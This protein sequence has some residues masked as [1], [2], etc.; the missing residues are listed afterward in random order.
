MDSAGY[1]QIT[2]TQDGGVTEVPLAGEKMVLGR[3]TNIEIPLPGQTVSRKHAELF[4]DPYGRWWLR[5]LGSRNGT[6]VNG[7]ELK[8]AYTLQ[9]G[10]TIQ[11]EEFAIRYR[12]SATQAGAKMPSSVAGMT[13]SAAGV[14]LGDAK[15]GPVRSLKDMTPP[16]I[17]AAHL[18]SLMKFAGDLLNTENDKTRL[19]MLCGLMV[20]ETF[21]GNAALALR[22]DL[23]NPGSEPTVLCPPLT[24]GRTK[25][26]YISKTLLK[27]VAAARSPVVASNSQGAG[28]GGGEEMVELSLVAAVQELSAVACPIASDDQH[29]D[30]LYLTLPSRFG[31]AEWLAL[32]SLAA[33]QYQQANTAWESRRAAQEQAVIEKELHRAREIQMRLVP[34]DFKLDGLDVGFGFEPCKWV[35]GDYVDSIR[36]ADGRQLIVVMDVCGK[37]MQAA[38]ITNGLHTTVHLLSA[39]GL[40]MVELVTKMNNHL[41]AS[42]PDESFVTMFALAIDPKSGE[43]EAVNCGHPPAFIVK[44]S[45]ETRQ[46]KSG[47]HPPL[48]YLEIEITAEPGKLEKRELIAA[49]TD[50]LS[51]MVNEEDKMLE[52]DGV[53]ERLQQVYSTPGSDSATR[54]NRTATQLAAALKQQLEHY[55]GAALPNDD[56]SFFVGVKS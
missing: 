22:L 45:G 21:H 15:V 3:A 54:F 12:K 40:G 19:K 31:T 41:V 20:G 30:L 53:R 8:D 36:L 49:Y 18:K 34:K 26:P 24:D 2:N 5:D 46:L 37:G 14:T 27:A 44:P 33:D 51:E 35:G 25:D 55:R 28:I 47:E 42:L 56:V 52:I 29:M 1:L 7:E 9:V 43:Y 48:G 13:M 6:L 39:Q 50:G 16:K 38:L 4:K 11:I 10:D 17:D 32:A 23:Q